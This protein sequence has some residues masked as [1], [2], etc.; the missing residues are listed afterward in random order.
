MNGVE[1]G[2]HTGWVTRRSPSIFRGTRPGARNTVTVRA[3]NA[4]SEAMLPRGRSSD[5]AHDGGIYRPVRL[6]ATPKAFVDSIAVDADPDLAANQAS[7]QITAGI[8]N[9]NPA[10]WQGQ[11]TS[12]CSMKPRAKRGSLEAPATAVQLG[13]GQRSALTLPAVKMS[14]PRLW[15]FDHPQL[16]RLGADLSSGHLRNHLRRAEDRGQRTPR[17][18]STASRC[19]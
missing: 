12:R 9:A 15:H 2:R 4:F 11:V 7:L 8:V 6:L 14:A 3:D 1:A 13:A 16:Y 10:A 18:I 19:G 17:S 5:W